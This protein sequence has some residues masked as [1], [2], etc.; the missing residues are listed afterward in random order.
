MGHEPNRLN[1]VLTHHPNKYEY[2][3][4]GV[5]QGVCEA[6][7][8][9]VQP[10]IARTAPQGGHEHEDEKHHVGAGVGEELHK[11]AAH[12]LAKLGK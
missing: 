11:R 1:T 10:G 8:G 5:W 7:A 9:H 3:D 4:N 2:D 12:L 6:P